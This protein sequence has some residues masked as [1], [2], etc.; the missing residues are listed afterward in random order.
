[1]QHISEG[2]TQSFVDWLDRSTPNRVKVAEQHEIL[3][4][5][6]IYFPPDGTHIAIKEGR[7]IL[8][9]E[10]P[11]DCGSRPSANV[12]FNSFADAGYSER[13]VAVLLSGMGRDGANGM[14]ALHTKG[15]FT[16]AQ[17]EQSCAIF[18]MPRE[19]IRLGAVDQVLPPHEIVKFLN[20]LC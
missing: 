19:A 16:I 2:F 6:T 13:T 15:A 3:H 20:E 5:G 12:L 4:S 18:G 7:I 9:S 10:S 14:A 17:S 8:D 1:V 11:L